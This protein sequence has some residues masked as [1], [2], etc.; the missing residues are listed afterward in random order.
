MTEARRWLEPRLRGIPSSLR[1]RMEAAL[2]AHMPR[3][4]ASPAQ[5]LRAVADALLEEAKR[6]GGA[7][8]EARGVALTLLAADALVTYACELEA[9][10]APER[11]AEMR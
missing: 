9:E 5:S 3:H 4:A 6:A 7:E 2:D 11:L 8:G 10:T 1:Q